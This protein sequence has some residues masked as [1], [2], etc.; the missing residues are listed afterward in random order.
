MTLGTSWKAH[1]STF[2][3]FYVALVLMIFTIVVYYPGY[4][5]PDSVAM[6]QMARTSVTS[7][8]YSPLM[9]YVWRITD[10]FVPGPGGMLILQALVYWLSLAL[11]AYSAGAGRIL[12]ILFVC[13]GLWIPT[14]AL[15]GTIWKD[16]GMQDFLLLGV[17]FALLGRRL[18]RTWPLLVAVVCLFFAC[19]Y[20][21][22]GILAAAPM[23]IVVL[24]YSSRVIPLP[25]RW[26]DDRLAPV[27]YAGAGFAILGAFL[28]GLWCLNSYKIADGKLWSAA[29]VHDLAAISV[30]QNTN[31]LPPYVNPG[32]AL[33]VEDLKHMYSPL[34]ANSL[35]LPESR[36]FLGV[37]DPS[38]DK[39]MAY[40]LTD[41]EARDLQFYWLTTVLDHFGSYLRHRSLMAE[42]LLVLMP[43]QPWY[44]YITGIDPNPYGITFHRSR[45]NGWVTK[46]TQYA[47][48]STQLYSAWMYYAV[49]TLCALVSFFWPFEH[50]LMVQCLGASVWLYFVSIFMFG[51]S[52]DFR[53]NIWALTCAPLCVFLLFCGR[54]RTNTALRAREG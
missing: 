17:A 25:S 32:N 54:T 10:W 21:Q 20:R 38:P 13:T 8:V 16:V 9:S 40:M 29:L 45:L 37:P 34:H 53:Y 2:C 1:L 18:G 43:R 5:S 31:Y 33:T 15:Q 23:L 50:A 42:R 11:I 36:K 14:F 41:K 47:A 46:V 12:G 44:P 24:D 6:L 26:T 48:F 19:G 30:F 35:F 4:M 51:M 22:N 52:G 7:N 28:G 49:V 3:V 27:I 39:V